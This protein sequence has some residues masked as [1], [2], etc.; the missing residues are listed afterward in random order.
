MCGGGAIRQNENQTYDRNHRKRYCCNWLGRYDVESRS[1]GHTLSLRPP[2]SCVS[3]C[4]A[5][6]EDIAFSCGNVLTASGGTACCI[7]IWDTRIFA[8]RT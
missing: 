4:G 6:G 2:H 7:H 3:P 8:H 1:R 5:E